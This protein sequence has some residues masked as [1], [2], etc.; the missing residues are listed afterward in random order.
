MKK[1]LFVGISLAT[2]LIATTLYGQGKPFNPKEWQT[3]EDYKPFG[4]P[5]AKKGGMLVSSWRDFPPTF[6]TDGPNSR[7]AQ[8]SQLHGMMYESLVGLHPT[9]LEFIPSLA[10][11]WQISEDKQTFRFRINPKARWWDGSPVTADDVVA[12][13]EHLTKED[14]KDPYNVYLYKQSYE[15][16]VAEDRLTV[17]VRARRLDWRLFL[18]FGGMSIYPA[19]YIRILGEEYLEKYQWKFIMG[20]G[21]HMLKQGDMEKGKYLILTRRKDYWAE[22]EKWNI[23]LNNFDKLKWIVVR[24]EQLTFEKFKKGELDYYS[25]GKAQRWVEETDFDK[26]KKGWIQKRKIYNEQPQG[27]SGYVF[28]MRKPPFNDVRVRL[29]FAHLFNRK[30]LMEKLFFNEYEHIDSYY[31]GRVWANPDNELVTYDPG[32]AQELLAEAGWKERNK[33]GWLVDENGNILEFTLE[34]AAE[35]WERIHKVVR[36]GVNKAGIKLNLK[37]VDSNTFIKKYDER[38]FTI[39]FM[40]W[41][42]LLFPNPESSWLSKLADGKNNNN[43]PGFKNKRVDELCEEYRRTFDQRRRV[44]MIREIDGII[45]NEHPYALGWYA[46]FH[47]LLYWNKFGHP[48]AYF[49]KIGGISNIISMWWIDEGR[50]K[51]LKKA[52]ANDTSLPVG[53]TVAKP[54]EKQGKTKIPASPEVKTKS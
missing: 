36:E 25:V 28:N 45:Y 22:N 6:R 34:Y 49:T 33:D 32:F 47:R 18:Y 39:L 1:A 38:Q 2:I 48:K 13:W 20:S 9:T 41:T 26:V 43:L 40:A 4:D 17:S 42:G 12:T 8:L 14:R 10:I 19:K 7:L 5:N 21:P 24:D 53:E 16:P 23:G 54:W 44:E 50:E 46:N 37:R 27:F 3:N 35:S 51:T 15:K 30:A 11:H 52:M 31:P 29:A